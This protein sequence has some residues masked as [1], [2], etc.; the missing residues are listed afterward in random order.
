M[1]QVQPGQSCLRRPGVPG[2]AGTVLRRSLG[3]QA[4]APPHLSPVWLSGYRGDVL[5]L[6]SEQVLVADPRLCRLPSPQPSLQG[7]SEGSVIFEY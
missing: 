3:R 2:P 5:A 6:T 4:G 1:T 7:Q